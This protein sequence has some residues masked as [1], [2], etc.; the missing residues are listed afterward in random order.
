MLTR[1]YKGASTAVAG[2]VNF[3]LVAS[4]GGTNFG[5]QGGAYQITMSLQSSDFGLGRGFYSGIAEFSTFAGNKA[6]LYGVVS[7]NV[8]AS[9]LSPTGLLSITVTASTSAVYEF[10]Q[11]QINY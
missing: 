8:N 3:Q 4:L 2:V 5:T 1:A 10:T 6:Q 7:N 11:L 9:S